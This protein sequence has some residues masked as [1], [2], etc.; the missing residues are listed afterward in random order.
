M[1]T[2]NPLTPHSTLSN[3]DAL[4]STALTGKLQQQ[5][6]SAVQIRLLKGVL[7]RGKHRDLWQ[8]LERDQYQIREYFSQIGL[9][10]SV[11]DAEGYAFLK[12]LDFDEESE[13]LELPRLITRRS[14][15]FNQTL[16]LVSLRKRL[17]EHDSEESSP[18][19]IVTRAEMHQWL[20]PY[21]S[22]V[23]NEVKQQ[24][25]FDA[26]IKKTVE[27]QFIKPLINHTD[28]FEI[29]RILKAFITAEQIMEFNQHL[30]T[31]A[32][33]QNEQGELV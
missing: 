20:L 7:Y 24:R 1:R 4:Q 32:T 19:L 5:Q 6:K 2:D 10:L 28:D 22:Q 29:L 23:S 21:F 17:A 33:N 13:I 12:Q 11:D 9:S 3:S 27:M 31:L 26:L 15:S 18:R 8:F 14:L 30:Q 25:D 16:L